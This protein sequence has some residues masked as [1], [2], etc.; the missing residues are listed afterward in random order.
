[1]LVLIVSAVELYLS[2]EKY[3]KNENLS[4]TE[5]KISLIYIKIKAPGEIDI[6][7]ID[8]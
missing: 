5:P 4:D 6:E 7:V 8:F 3:L 2:I 1:M